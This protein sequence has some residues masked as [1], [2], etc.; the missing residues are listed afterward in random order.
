MGEA[1]RR[2][3]AGTMP[4]R[5]PPLTTHSLPHEITERFWGLVDKLLPIEAGFRQVVTDWKRINKQVGNV[6][7]FGELI[8]QATPERG[9]GEVILR[10]PEQQEVDYFRQFLLAN[11]RADMAI[12]RTV[13]GF[14]LILTVI[15]YGK[16]DYVSFTYAHMDQRWRLLILANSDGLDWHGGGRPE[17]IHTTSV[18]DVNRHLAAAAAMTIRSYGL[19]N[20]TGP[21]LYKNSDKPFRVMAI[22]GKKPATAK[23]ELPYRVLYVNKPRVIRPIDPNAE[24]VAGAPKSPHIR[25][26]HTFTRNGITRKRSGSK[27]HGGVSDDR[28]YIVRLSHPLTDTVH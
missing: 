14:T 25:K 5:L 21:W 26:E 11:E 8:V 2:K 20:K 7:D 15:H 27:I 18:A 13:Y 12:H 28:P 16:V 10:G 1:R 3:L 19:L 24:H 6:Y 22:E 17:D 4:V 23:A 9:V